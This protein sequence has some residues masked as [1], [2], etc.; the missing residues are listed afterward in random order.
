[1]GEVT[2]IPLARATEH[3]RNIPASSA[4]QIDTNTKNPPSSSPFPFWSAL[5]GSAPPL[6]PSPPGRRNRTG[7]EGQPWRGAPLTPGDQW[8]AAGVE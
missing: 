4:Q 2:A 8:Q 3:S 1:M 7:H 5:T 6:L